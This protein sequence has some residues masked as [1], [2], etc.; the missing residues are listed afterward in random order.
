MSTFQIE[1]REEENGTR[2]ER[3]SH[4]EKIDLTRGV[5]FIGHGKWTMLANCPELCFGI[6]SRGGG[7]LKDKWRNFKNLGKEG[8]L[9]FLPDF[10]AE[11]LTRSWDQ[12]LEGFCVRSSCRHEVS[13][14]CTAS[15]SMASWTRCSSL[16]T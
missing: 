12:S 11:C 7:S 6:T 1:Q 3:Y 16:T 5:N 14:S 9:Y 15:R 13:L 4:Q 10:K 8:E 2:K